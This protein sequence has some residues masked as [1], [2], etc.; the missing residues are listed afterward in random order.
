MSIIYTCRHCGQQVGKLNQKIVDTTVLGFDQ[1]T[2][3]EKQYMIHYKD[4]GD[5]QIKTICESCENTLGEHPQYHELD[6]FI[7]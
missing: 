3:E 6:F 2:V 4:N 7:Q 1:L 5:I